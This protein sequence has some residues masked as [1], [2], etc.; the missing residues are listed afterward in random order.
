MG[1]KYRKIDIPAKRSSPVAEKFS[2]L[3]IIS[4]GKQ[5]FFSHP[6]RYQARTRLSKIDIPA[7]R[8]SPV[9]L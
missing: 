1:K 9:Y 3:L 2:T 4:I 7:K 5:G 8:S 6:N